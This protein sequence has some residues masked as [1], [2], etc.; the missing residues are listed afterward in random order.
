[1]TAGRAVVNDNPDS[2]GTS[3]LVP[4]TDSIRVLALDPAIAAAA[5]ES[6]LSR[7]DARWLTSMTWNLNDEPTG[8][9]SVVLQAGG[10]PGLPGI[11][12]QTATFDS[13]VLKP[14]PT[15]GVAGITFATTYINTNSPVQTINPSYAP[16]LQFQFEQPLLQGFGVEINQV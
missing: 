12:T 8:N 13:S 15:G 6:S 10:Q 2:F 14:L 5:I 16:R 1:F 9:P 4:T 3:S 7:F 11:T